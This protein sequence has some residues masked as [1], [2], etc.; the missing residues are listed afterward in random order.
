VPVVASRVGGIPEV[1]QDGVSG[2]LHPVNDLDGMAASAIRLLSDEGL[3]RQFAQ[4]AKRIAHEKF[5]ESKIV[6]VY[7][8]YYREVLTT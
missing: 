1:I 2:F 5:C 4:A 3:H 7:E 6:P 8:Q